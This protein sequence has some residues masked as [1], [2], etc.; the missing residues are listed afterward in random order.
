MKNKIRKIFDK[1]R[2]TKMYC[3]YEVP[4]WEYFKDR[5]D[6]TTS[7]LEIGIQEGKSLLAWHAFF[8]NARIF[9]VDIDGACMKMHDPENRII[10][11][12]GDQGNDAF[13]MK[14]SEMAGGF[15]IVIDDGSHHPSHQIG[16]FKTL[17]PLLRYG[18]IYV[19]EDLTNVTAIDF[20]AGLA[21]NL[22]HYEP[23]D[24][25]KNG[26]YFKTGDYFDRNITGISW[27]RWICFVFKGSNPMNPYLNMPG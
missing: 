23:S 19:C 9:G 6:R 16:S 15:D 4:Y 2:P 14:I 3:N 1:H 20:F 5:R 7:V 17:F 11:K 18:G 27:S 26:G 8:R 21:R 25:W 10:V 22:N 13:L 12:I 24:T